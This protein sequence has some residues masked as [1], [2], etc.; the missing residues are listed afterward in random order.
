M[1]SRWLISLTILIRRAS[2]QRQ[3][4]VK[5]KANN[6]HFHYVMRYS[7]ATP[8]S[9]ETMARLSLSVLGGFSARPA[10]AKPIILPTKKSQGLLAYLALRPGHVYARER[11][12]TLL[13]GDSAEDQARHS[14]RQALFDLRKALPRTKPEIL[15]SD[16]DGVG[17]NPAT[18][19]V[20]AATF[21]RLV[22]EGTPQAL[23][24]AADL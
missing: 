7:S 3:A 12:A 16:G 9:R 5:R 4:A 19:D 2:G 8:E 21:E 18:V 15:Q 24:Q 10:A 11:L 20:D 22:A 23:A 1:E 13:W 14:L 6:R 17:L